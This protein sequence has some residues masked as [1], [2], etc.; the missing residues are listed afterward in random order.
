[1]ISRSVENY[2]KTIFLLS[3]AG[4]ISVSTNSIA[5]KLKTQP[6]SVTDM[7]KKLTSKRL[8]RYEKYKGVQLTT[9]G[10]ILATSIVRKHR[11][12]ETFLFE[13]LGFSW[14]EVHDIA[15]QLEHIKSDKLVNSLDKF[16]EH[17]QFD[18]HGD[19]IPNHEGDFPESN[20][21]PLNEI[22]KAEKGIIMGVLEDST[23]FLQL[24]DKAKIKIGDEIS[25]DDIMQFDKSMDIRI[26]NRIHHV[27]LDVAKNILVKRKK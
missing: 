10:K 19:P 4:D 16:L 3:E 22:G 12:W 6:S 11:L 1:M 7:I 14:D 17:P 15:E 20:S 23:D 5:K 21:I 8:L 13:K 9:K 27:S 26:N 18:P 2:L 24:L 25:V